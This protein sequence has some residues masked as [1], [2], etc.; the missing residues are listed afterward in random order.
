MTKWQSKYLHIYL[1]ISIIVKI[2]LYINFIRLYVKR[3]A[4]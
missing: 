4:I 2:T 1:Q 3:M